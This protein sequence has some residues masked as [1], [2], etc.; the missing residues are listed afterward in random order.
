MITKNLNYITSAANSGS[1]ALINLFLFAGDSPTAPGVLNK[2]FKN[3]TIVLEIVFNKNTFVPVEF[4]VVLLQFALPFW[5][6]SS[7]WS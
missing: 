6:F 5:L 2:Q 7:Y 4:L 1:N 3:I